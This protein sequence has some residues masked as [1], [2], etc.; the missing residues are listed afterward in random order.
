M[1]M[2]FKTL[3]ISLFLSTSAF[4]GTKAEAGTEAGTRIAVN[5]S[6]AHIHAGTGIGKASEGGTNGSMGE[7]MLA[8]W[9]QFMGFILG[10]REAGTND[11]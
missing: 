6:A 4:A 11:D 9:D 10:V 7:G 5:G 3:L 2:L 8:L 1:K